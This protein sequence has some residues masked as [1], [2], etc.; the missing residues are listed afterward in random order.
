M[1]IN[2]LDVSLETTLLWNYK[3]KL[4]VPEA[5][6]T[7]SSVPCQRSCV[8]RFDYSKLELQG[9]IASIF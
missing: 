6:R 5:F 9:T 1:C 2:D 3:T 4:G 7:L 8:L